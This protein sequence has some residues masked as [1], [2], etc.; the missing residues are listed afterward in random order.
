MLKQT[1]LFGFLAA[2][3]V[4]SF[5]SV[6]RADSANNGQ[7]SGQEAAAVGAFNTVRQTTNQFS[8]FNVQQPTSGLLGSGSVANP[9]TSV[10]SAKQAAS[11]VGTG[12]QIQ[13]QTG[14]GNLQQ[15]IGP[16]SSLIPLF[17]SIPQ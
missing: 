1:C 4:M 9:A 16:S 10:Q 15:L 8:L 6:A 3:T 5:D 14:Q 12:N 11:A 7:L 13:Q 2:A 17:P